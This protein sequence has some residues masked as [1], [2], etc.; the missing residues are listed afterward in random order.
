MDPNVFNN[1]KELDPYMD[2]MKEHITPASSGYI[3]F[4]FTERQYN[5]YVDS[6][7]VRHGLI[8]L[9][10]EIWMSRQNFLVKMRMDQL[11]TKHDRTQWAFVYCR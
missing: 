11:T 9:Y 10:D 1:N 2:F 6:E 8:Q 3:P 4:D 7:K 5:A